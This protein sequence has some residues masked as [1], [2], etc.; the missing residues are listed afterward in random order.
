MSDANNFDA[1]KGKLSE[2]FE[3]MNLTLQEEKKNFKSEMDRRKK[4]IYSEIK[5]KLDELEADKNEL[6]KVKIQLEKEA[7]TLQQMKNELQQGKA[8]LKK[9]E[10]EKNQAV[11]RENGKLI[12]VEARTEAL[13]FLHNELVQEKKKLEKDLNSLNEVRKEEEELHR[14]KI[15]A[16][17]T[18]LVELEDQIEQKLYFIGDQEPTNFNKNNRELIVTTVTGDTY[19]GTINISSKERLSDMFTKVKI[20]FIVMY[21]VTF[22]GE[23]KATIILNKQNIVFFTSLLLDPV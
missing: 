14:N 5:A 11:A 2:E 1:L 18:Q 21:D 4:E 12:E 15:A 10:E 20:P 19:K 17:K 13:E 23:Q 8:S 9:I 22:K 6:N 16:L 7:H 3:K